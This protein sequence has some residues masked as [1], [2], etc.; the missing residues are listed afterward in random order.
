MQY[1]ASTRTTTR[2]SPAPTFH[3][4][5]SLTSWHHHCVCPLT[6]QFVQTF[7]KRSRMGTVQEITWGRIF[8]SRGCYLIAHRYLLA[9]S[10]H[11][12]DAMARTSRVLPLLTGATIN[13]AFS[14]L[15]VRPF[16]FGALPQQPARH[17]CAA[18]YVP[19]VAKRCVGWGL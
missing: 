1:Y 5:I 3:L 6:Q 8:E 14:T 15:K 13:H 17:R 19:T 2:L 7:S 10:H 18:D 12:Y 16:R 9:L 11:M 4:L